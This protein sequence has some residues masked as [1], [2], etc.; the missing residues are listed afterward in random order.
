MESGSGD[1][2]DS[3]EILSINVRLKSKEDAMLELMKKLV[4]SIKANTQVLQRWT[5]SNNAVTKQIRPH[6]IDS[7]GVHGSSLKCRKG[8]AGLHKCSS[9]LNEEACSLFEQAVP[10]SSVTCC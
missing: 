3:G 1:S 8:N 7:E 10:G 6:N 9:G 2:T 5:E 4:Q